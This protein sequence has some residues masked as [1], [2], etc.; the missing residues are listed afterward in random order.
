MSVTSKENN[1]KEENNSVGYWQLLRQNS[2][3]RRLWT[4]QLISAA[5]DWFNSVAVLGL[6][7]KLTN[8]GFSASLVILCSSLPAFFLI[9][10]AGPVADRFDRR[11]LMIIANIVSVAIALLFLL[12]HS[13]DGIWL[14]YLASMLLVICASFFI[15]ASSASVPNIVKPEELFAANALS[16][17]TWGIM[18]MVG[19]ALGGVVTAAFGNE[20]AFIVN[21]LSFLVAGLL[22]WTIDIPSPKRESKANPW[23]DFTEG[24]GYLR[25][26]LPAAGLVTVKAGWGLSG[27]VIV[28]LSVFSEQVFKAGDA[29]IGALYSARGM[30]ALIGPIVIQAVA[31]Q[32][33]EKLRTAIWVG[34]ILS[35]IGYVI[36]AASGW[37]D[38]IWL[39]FI[40]L[41]IA[42]FGGGIT[43]TISS[44]L[45]QRTTPD[46]FRGRVFAVD[47]GFSTLTTGISTLI[48]GLALQAGSLPMALSLI[49]AAIFCIFGAA[50]GLA[51]MRGKLEISTATTLKTL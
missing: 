13:S 39:G 20:V 5:G 47:N 33:V 9:P 22:I 37:L 49:G 30:G 18:V 40:A 1:T 8:S 7:L 17:A 15:P 29:G 16:G 50:W 28:L 4:A 44:V 48:F 3:F 10:F 31:K 32:H 34:F 43:W 27:G 2:R 36:F 42:H 23:R 46:R 24:L 25:E 45:L 38:F 6:V 14:V 12:V 35:G 41:L 26:Y 51:T 19:S 21:S 11:A